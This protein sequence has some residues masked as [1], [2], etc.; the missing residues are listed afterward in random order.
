M[1]GDTLLSGAVFMAGLASFFAPCT[2]PLLP[3]YIGLLTDGKR[4][5]RTVLRSLA[6]VL[7]ISTTFITL[8]F[9]AGA[10]GSFMVRYTEWLAIIGGGIVVIMGLHQMEWIRLRFLE[11]SFSLRR[12]RKP[13]GKSGAT[14]SGPQGYS[15]INAF[16]L[17]V[18]LSF[19]WT[20]CVGPVLGAVLV[21]T[22]TQST[23]WLGAAMM[24]LYA[25]GLSIPFLVLAM[26][27]GLLL[28]KLTALE[29]YLPRIKFF[30]G[31]LVVLMGILLMTGQ[32]NVLTK[33]LYQFS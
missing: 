1:V 33:W 13:P 32:L 18:T 8:G 31:L 30:G 10:L 2:F 5:T 24:G 6:F 11:G 22:A 15:L 20:P 4:W 16:V 12:R 3:A 17:G 25:A 9:G 7:G 21:T 23:Q 27:S 29:K 28:N 26:A 19:G 14:A